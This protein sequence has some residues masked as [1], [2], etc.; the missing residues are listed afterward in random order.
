MNENKRNKVLTYSIL[1]FISL[2]FIVPFGYALYTSLLTKSDIDKIVP[3]SRL[4]LENY[5][6]I[7]LNS[8]VLLWYKNSIIMTLGILAG[9]LVFNTL[10]GYALAKLKFK[11]KNIIFFIIIGTMMVPYQLCLIP[12]YGMIVKLGWL[13]SFNGLII[14][15]LFQGFLVF[16]MRQFF[17]TIPD[18]LIEAAKID[19]LGP[20]GTF[21]KIIL[22]MAKTAMATQVIFSFTGTWNSFMWPVILT[23]DKSKFVLTVGLNT[24]KNKYFEWPNVTMTGIVLM[25]IPIVIVF[26]VFQKYFVEG[27]ASSGVKG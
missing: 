26:I 11:G 17:L 22:P 21:F 25:T 1:L 20:F 16:L 15:F 24:L 10:A 7:F 27:I 23:N 2:F 8:D 19:G 12:I 4:T 9:N 18:E 3:L 6:D 13:N 5:K 14:P